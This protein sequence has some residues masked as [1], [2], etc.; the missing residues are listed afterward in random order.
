M[1]AKLENVTMNAFHTKYNNFVMK[2]RSEKDTVVIGETL[3]LTINYR[4]QLKIFNLT[5]ITT[6]TS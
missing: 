1:V 4:R 3:A 5:P 2:F 6:K